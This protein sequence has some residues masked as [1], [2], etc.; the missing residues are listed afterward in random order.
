MKLIKTLACSSALAIAFAAVAPIAAA[1]TIGPAGASFSAPGTI[2]VSTPIAQNVS[3]GITLSGVVSS[4]GT[5]AQINSVALTGGGLCGVPQIIG[6]PWKLVATSTTA[7]NVANVGFSVLGANC[8]PSTI[9]GAW[10]N[11]TD[12]LSASNQ[13]LTGNCKINSLSVSPNPAFTVSP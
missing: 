4:D 11:A 8:G 3:C 7:G 9:N 1:A 6:L 2:N 13:P 5:Y 12:T 10:S